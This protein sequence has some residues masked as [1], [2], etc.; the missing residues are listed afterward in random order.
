MDAIV[1]LIA[2]IFPQLHLLAA[3]HIDCSKVDLV[4]EY[5]YYGIAGRVSD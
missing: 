2:A 4:R 3:R 1:L 5:G